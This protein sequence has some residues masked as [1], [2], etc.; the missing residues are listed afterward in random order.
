M[1]WIIL[2]L[3]ILLIAALFG[4]PFI[5]LLA[6]NN[7]IYLIQY[8]PETDD[9]HLLAQG[10]KT[11][12]VQWQSW[13]YIALFCLTLCLIGAVTSSIIRERINQKIKDEKSTLDGLIREQRTLNDSYRIKV[14]KEVR[15][16][17]ENEYRAKR[18]WLERKNIEQYQIGE[19]LKTE[20]KIN[21]NIKDRASKLNKE[22]NISNQ[23]QERSNRSKLAQRDRLS[24]Q[25]KLLV[26]Y[27]EHSDW[28]WKTGEKV[29]YHSLLREAKRSQ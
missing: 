8:L 15:E 26:N 7:N 20:R 3:V 28:R 27:L 6:P 12:W 18:E 22:T 29:T 10:V 4:A 21:E 9:T 16:A 23:K 2:G 19:Q 25:K 17:L 24:V 13:G 1:I 11:L 5:E 14:E